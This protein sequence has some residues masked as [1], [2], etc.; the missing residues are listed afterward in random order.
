VYICAAFGVVNDCYLLQLTH[1]GDTFEH[2]RQNELDET[3][4][5]GRLRDLFSIHERSNWKSLFFLS[6][7]LQQQTDARLVY[8][9]YAPFNTCSQ[10]YGVMFVLVNK[11][12][13][14][15]LSVVV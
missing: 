5:G 13:I 3:N 14:I 10:I 12:L 1:L 2:R 6:V 9:T 11:W 8:S 15:R 4:L 7:W